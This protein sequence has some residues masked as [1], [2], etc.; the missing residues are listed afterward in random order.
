VKAFYNWK[1]ALTIALPLILASIGVSLLTFDLIGRVSTGSNTEDHERTREIVSS[2]LA[3]V[4]QQLANTATDNAYWDDAARKIYGAVDQDWAS[5]T[6]GAPSRDSVNYDVMLIFDR[7][8][9]E[10]VTGYRNGNAFRPAGKDYFTDKLDALLDRLPQDF[11]SSAAEAAIINT[12]DGLAVVAA[13][14]VIPTSEDVAVEAARP[15]YLV[16][17][18]FLTPEYVEAIGRQYVIQDLK[19]LQPGMAGAGETMKDSS[20]TAF[21]AAQW[22]DRR[23]GD[24]ARATVTRKAAVALGF[25]ALV[26]FGVGLL[27]WRLVRAIA[28]RESAA[29]HDALHDPLTGLSNRAA[30]HGEIAR[31]AKLPAAPVFVAF[32]D[33]DGFKEVNDTY[34]HATGDKLIQAIAAGL[35]HLVQGKGM[36]CRLGGDEFVALFSGQDAGQQASSFAR[37]FIE[38]LRVPFDLE[39]RQASVGASIGIAGWS[40]A[41]P[42]AHELMRRADI[43]MYRA[44][45]TG[46]N[47]YSVYTPDLDSERTENLGIAHELRGIIAE[48]RLEVA[49]QPVVDAATRQIVGVEA[50]AR[51]PASSHRRITPDRFIRVA[52]TCGL[53]DDLGDLIL[54]KACGDATLWPTLRLSVNISTVQLKNPNFVQRTLATIAASGVDPGRI[55]IEITESTLVDDVP[56]AQEI[57]AAL[58][59]AGLHIALDDFGTGYSSIGYLR[60]FKFDRIKIDRSLVDQVISGSAEQHIVQGT[61]MMAAGMTAAVTAEGVEREEQINILR[62][63]GCHELQGFYFYRPMPAAEISSLM[64][65]DAASADASAAHPPADGEDE[66]RQTA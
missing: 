34:D 24:F 38:F 59:A 19:L 30:L 56:K 36:V 46:K 2:A 57:F 29:L 25:M 58:R 9:P 17:A 45:S 42:E 21:A 54:A 15:R 26:M 62:L 20:G 66:E 53:I 22:T 35:L 60:Q 39:G 64:A 28:K 32:A 18:K 5:E 44:K 37:H 47:R 6:W 51:W 61:M 11:K 1:F 49:Y 48:R 65:G 10:A 55:E 12:A 7:G 3:A 27:C 23:P 16:F 63:T 13:S 41:A 50:L 8:I 33:L 52:E 14:P 4:Q 40:D 31:L 43:A